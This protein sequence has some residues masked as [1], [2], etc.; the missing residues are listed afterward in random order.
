MM[1]TAMVV[2]AV[3]VSC[4]GSATVVDGGA[5]AQEPTAAGPT[6]TATTA[7]EPTVDRSVLEPFVYVVHGRS[8]ADEFEP[9]VYV[10]NA[11]RTQLSVLVAESMAESP[12]TRV[13]TAI[14]L[15]D[16]AAHLIDETDGSD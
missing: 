9:G 3:A 5:S 11:G 16:D 13:E 10:G 14:G 4:G 2:L 15:D 7:P 12:R 1:V 8:D 6:T